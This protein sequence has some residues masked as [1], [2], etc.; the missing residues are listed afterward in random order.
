MFWVTSLLA[1]LCVAQQSLS[2]ADNMML[3]D[4]MA[5]SKALGVPLTS[6]SPHRGDPFFPLE[7]I[8][9]VNNMQV[10]KQNVKRQG[11]LFGDSVGFIVTNGNVIAFGVLW[12]R[13]SYEAAHNALMLEL[14]SNNMSH[15]MRVE[16]FNVCPDDIGDFCIINTR[17]D[18]ITRTRMSDFSKLYFVRGAKAISLRGKDGADVRPIAKALDELL[19]QPP[20]QK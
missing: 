18:M 10:V 3:N 12:E 17:F 6:T 5:L 16:T 20:R 15:R 4:A 2:K 8:A 13:T 9:H 7:G 19:K 14:V 11:N 1:L